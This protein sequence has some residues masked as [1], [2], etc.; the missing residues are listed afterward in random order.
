MLSRK[1]QKMMPQNG[2]DL[3]DKVKQSEFDA[4]HLMKGKACKCKT[5][6]VAEWNRIEEEKQRRIHGKI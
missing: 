2:I 1:L 3:L 5:R 6:V 4:K